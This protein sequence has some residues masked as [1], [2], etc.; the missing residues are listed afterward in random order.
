MISHEI[1]KYSRR[2][3][4]GSFVQYF[5]KIQK[6]KLEVTLSVKKDWTS[7]PLITNYCVMRYS[8][9]ISSNS[10]EFNSNARCTRRSPAHSQ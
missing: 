8:N 2:C 1:I 4:S 6:I 9:C 3:V 5:M 10:L 7:V